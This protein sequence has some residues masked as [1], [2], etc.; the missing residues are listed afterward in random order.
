M[1]EAGDES[2]SSRSVN[3]QEVALE[4]YKLLGAIIRHIFGEFWQTNAFF[5]SFF[6]AITLAL[7]LNLDNLAQ[8]HWVLI[9]VSMVGV[10]VLAGVWWISNVKHRYYIDLHINHAMQ[11]EESL[12]CSIYTE[13]L[14]KE[15]SGI[16]RVSARKAW[17][18]VPL[19]FILVDYAVIISALLLES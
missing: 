6:T 5:M 13:R 8:A 17:G 3:A 14:T 2:T 18:S 11:L 1:R 12:G 16:A 19:V 9:A 10:L 15:P 4:E 7:F